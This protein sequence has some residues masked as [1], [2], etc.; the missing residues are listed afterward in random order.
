MTEQTDSPEW[1]E[2]LEAHCDEVGIPVRA[3][4]VWADNF[5]LDLEAWQE[6]TDE[7]QEAYAGDFDCETDFAQELA[8][9]TGLIPESMPDYW[10]DWE[11]IARDL[12][13]SDYWASDRYYFRNY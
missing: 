8:D 11:A 1:Q 2:E 7:L 4:E 12:L 9:N 10:V 3:Y 6:F 5:H 13:I